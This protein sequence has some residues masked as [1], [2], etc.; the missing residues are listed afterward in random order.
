AFFAKLGFAVVPMATLPFK[1]WSDCLKCP[2]R[3][4]C[5][6]IA[7]VRVLRD[8]P[9]IAEADPNQAAA[10]RYEVPT[11]LVQIRTATSNPETK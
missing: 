10:G 1:V 3:E 7:M 6:E 8:R 5:D 2:K 4:G 9:A 11:R